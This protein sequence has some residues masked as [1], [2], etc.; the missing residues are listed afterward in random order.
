MAKIVNEA[1]ELDLNVR[2]SVVCNGVTHTGIVVRCGNTR[3]W[4]HMI[5]EQ[6][7][8][9]VEFQTDEDGFKIL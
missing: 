3:T 6:T 1:K 5:S 7:G 8:D 2:V 9:H 4:G